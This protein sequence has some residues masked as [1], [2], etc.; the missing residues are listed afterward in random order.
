MSAVLECFAAT[1]RLY[2]LT[3][4]VPVDKRDEAIQEIES[5]INQRDQLLP[6]IQ[7]PFSPDEEKM[8]KQMVRW[9]EEIGKNLE[10]I[11]RLIKRDINGLSKKKTSVRRYMNPY[12]NLQFD[13]MFYDKR[14]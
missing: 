4:D 7:P 6:S 8:G 9:N 2:E 14:K 12:E 1:K 3:V 10:L 5:L 13:G 11:K